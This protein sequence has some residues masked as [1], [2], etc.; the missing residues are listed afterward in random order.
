[1]LSKGPRS[2][3]FFPRAV[4]KD[5]ARLSWSST[6][7]AMTA[8]SAR[9]ASASDADS[10]SPAASLLKLVCTTASALA[11]SSASAFWL[12]SQTRCASTLAARAFFF[13]ATAAVASAAC[14]VHD[15]S[16]SALAD[17][18]LSAASLAASSFTF[19]A[20]TSATFSASAARVRSFSARK[21][22]SA[23]AVISTTRLWHAMR[24]SLGTPRLCGKAVW[25]IMIQADGRASM[26]LTSFRTTSSIS[27][28]SGFTTFAFL[29]R[30]AVADDGRLTEAFGAIARSTAVPL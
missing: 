13:P 9:C 23:S 16:S 30:A 5:A 10:Q 8:T 18:A 25:S 1:M 29:A 20:S 2:A 24:S 14:A 12:T 26:R 28:C 6:L 21:P 19:C 4:R 11:H 7:P 27:S 3:G 22:A 15:V 17:S